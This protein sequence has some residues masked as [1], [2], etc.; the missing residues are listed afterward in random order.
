MIM[1]YDRFGV[2][3]F[4][5]IDVSKH[6]TDKSVCLLEFRGCSIFFRH[7]ITSVVF[8]TFENSKSRQRL[9]TL[10]VGAVA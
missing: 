7:Y 6:K 9:I 4:A 3:G 5:K 10:I 1:V 2:S 8:L